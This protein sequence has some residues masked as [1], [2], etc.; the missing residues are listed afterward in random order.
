MK[1]RNTLVVARF[2]AMKRLMAKPSES[3]RAFKNRS[4]GTSIF[5]IRHVCAIYMGFF[6][7]GYSFSKNFHGFSRK[8]ICPKKHPC[9]WVLRNIFHSFSHALFG[10]V[11]HNPY[12]VGVRNSTLEV[13]GPRDTC[14]DLMEFG[15]VFR[16]PQF[17]MPQSHDYLV[18]LRNL[19]AVIVA[20]GAEISGGV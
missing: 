1:G 3:V 13:Q 7:S 2:R 14:V 4:D 16:K 12:L 20:A 17:G 10:W 19:Q 8:W 18:K 6:S 11:V 5:A 9:F 15:T